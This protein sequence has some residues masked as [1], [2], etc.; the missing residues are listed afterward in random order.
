MGLS[1]A[2]RC[3]ELKNLMID[4]I[5]DMQSH[6]IVHIRKTKTGKSRTFMVVS[7]WNELTNDL[8]LVEIYRKY[9]SLRP[10]SVSHRRLFI[11]YQKGK[12]TVQPVGIN[13]FA[14]IPQ[15]IA[16]FLK[17]SDA[18]LFT[19]HC[20]RRTSAT[21]L[22]DGGA[23]LLTLKRHG[24]WKSSAVAERYLEDS[25]ERKMSIA[26]KILGDHNSSNPSIIM[27]STSRST[28]S[29]S[30]IDEK[31]VES[32]GSGVSINANNCVLNF[33]INK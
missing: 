5:K 23:D 2:C 19:G 30:T 28:T 31:L 16:K 25:S 4:D 8:N 10:S 15:M 9:L 24:G 3:D 29:T 18:S 14:K 1:G 6:L 33:H 12:C 21:L 20:W 26:R 22:V 7:V 13:K 17:I 32:S 11:N 27:S